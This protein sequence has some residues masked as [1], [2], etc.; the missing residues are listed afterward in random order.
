MSRTEK[1]LQAW[2]RK[3]VSLYDH[4]GISIDSATDGVYRCSAPCHRNNADHDGSVHPAVIWLLAELAGALALIAEGI[5]EENFALVRRVSI[6]FKKLATLAVTAEVEFTEEDMADVFEVLE[7]EGHCDVDV[8]SIVRDAE[9]R[10]IAEAT[11]S[12]T[13]RARRS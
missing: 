10:V 4:I 2:A 12:Y 11:C 1:E 5:H 8:L 6:D 7:S 9:G 13:I 3:S